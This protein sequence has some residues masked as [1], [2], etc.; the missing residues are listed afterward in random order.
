MISIASVIAGSTE[1]VMCDVPGRIPIA[2][3]G[4]PPDRRYLRECEQPLTPLPERIVW[5]HVGMVG[6]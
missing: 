3:A 2:F 1:T 6:R 4:E 5:Q